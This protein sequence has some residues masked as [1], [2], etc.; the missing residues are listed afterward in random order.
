MFKH[1]LG[2]KLLMVCGYRAEKLTH[3]GRGLGWHIPVQPSLVA[4]ASGM[5]LEIPSTYCSCV[6]PLVACV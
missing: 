5:L 3:T 2:C 6:I 1:E 4:E